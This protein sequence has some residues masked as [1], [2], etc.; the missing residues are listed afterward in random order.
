METAQSSAV[1]SLLQMHD[2]LTHSPL[3]VQSLGQS[4]LM[5]FVKKDGSFCSSSLLSLIF[6]ERFL[7]TIPPHSL[8]IKDTADV[9]YV[10]SPVALKERSVNVQSR[11]TTWT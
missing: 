6:E 9:A 11:V 10:V 8:I 2:P 7:P 1:N 5:M 4:F 3:N